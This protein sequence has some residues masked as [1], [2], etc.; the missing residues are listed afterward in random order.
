MKSNTCKHQSGCSRPATV[1]TGDGVRCDFHAGWDAGRTAATT[2]SKEKLAA[3]AL[4]IYE[5]Q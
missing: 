4:A 2:A 3:D 1:V 5:Q